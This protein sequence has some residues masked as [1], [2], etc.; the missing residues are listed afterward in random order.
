MREFIEWYAPFQYPNGKVPCCVDHRG[1]DPVPEHDSHGELIYLIA[2]YYRYTHDRALL[3]RMWPHVEKAVAYIDSLRQSR[4]T[5]EYRSGD[6]RAFYGLVPESI[7][8]EGYSAKPM[9][10]FWDDFFVLRGLEDATYIAGVL[11]RSDEGRR[12]AA[13]RDDMRRSIQQS[14]RLTMQQHQIDYIPGS[15]ELGDF[16]ATSTT[17]AIA[18]GGELSH[19]PQDAVRR[20]FEKYWE[21]A[22][23]RMNGTIEW[24]AYT[25]YEL[26]TVGTFVR[27]GWKDRAHELL[28]F[29][30]RDRRPAAWNQ[31]AE[32]VWHDPKTPKFI[33]DMPHTWVGSDFIRSVLDMFAYEREADG[34][35]VVG[36][37]V[38][39]SWVTA[40]S[41]VRVAR[42]FTAHGPLAFTMRGTP[43]EARVSIAPGLHIPPGGIVLR[44]PFARP[45]RSATVNGRSITP[46]SPDEIVLRELPAE[47]TLRYR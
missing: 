40:D 14:L 8:H 34:A 37:G 15:V 22:R 29:F 12:F 31:W 16:D 41:G 18:P 1:A 10:S 5:D 35:L 43:D 13:M 46:A 7:S 25:P 39:E 17:I 33:G 23:G 27:L 11:G 24:D 47:V 9:H 32:V 26:R 19:L 44:S 2:E 21:H 4:M 28:D 3:E 30:M 42:L 20:T 45:I 36:A 38:P 6:K